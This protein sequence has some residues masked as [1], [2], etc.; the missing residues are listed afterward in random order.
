MEPFSAVIQKSNYRTVTKLFDIRVDILTT[1]SF[2]WS[3]YK[4]MC[5]VK[6]ISAL[7]FFFFFDEGIDIPDILLHY[8]V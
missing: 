6:I 4:I 7:R 1:E 5:L 3:W 8:N 2:L